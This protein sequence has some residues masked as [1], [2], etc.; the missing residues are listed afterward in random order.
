MLTFDC[1]Q[2]MAGKWMGYCSGKC[3]QLTVESQTVGTLNILDVASTRILLLVE[4]FSHLCD[5]MA[6]VAGTSSDGAISTFATR[7]II[8]S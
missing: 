5:H 7:S 8:N 2:E 4:Y 3:M 1:S 6:F